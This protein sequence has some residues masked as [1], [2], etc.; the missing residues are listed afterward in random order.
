MVLVMYMGGNRYIDSS[1]DVHEG[2]CLMGGSY[3]L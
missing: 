2:V 3:V 1:I